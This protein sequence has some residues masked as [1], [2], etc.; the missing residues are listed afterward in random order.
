MFKKSDHVSKKKRG[1]KIIFL[2]QILK[3]SKNLLE[4][5]D[6]TFNVI[7]LSKTWS[8]DEAFCNNS[9]IQLQNYEAIHFQRDLAKRGGGLLIYVKND[10]SFKIRED[11][12]ISDGDREFL[13]IEIINDFSKN[14]I[15]LL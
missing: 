10:L 3:N 4:E 15:M 1:L 11:L 14:Y 13:S 5:T 6:Y 9:N 2:L 12:N 8:T 7:C